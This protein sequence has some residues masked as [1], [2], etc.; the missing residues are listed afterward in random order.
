MS[1]KVLLINDCDNNHN[2]NENKFSNGLSNS[3]IKLNSVPLSVNKIRLYFL[4]LNQSIVFMRIFSAIFY[5]F[6]SFL[7]IVVNKVILTTYR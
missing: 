2:I 3:E 6:S 7:I 5:G 4:S 1:D